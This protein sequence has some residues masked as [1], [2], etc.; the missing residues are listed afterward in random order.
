[1]EDNR[2]TP[3]FVKI[4][5]YEDI[6]NIMN[7]VKKNISQSKSILNKLTEL[8]NQ[9]DIELDKWYSDINEVESKIKM[10]DNTLFE[11]SE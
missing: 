8:K 11:H 7:I 9:E 4:D 2:N 10:I 1:M 5:E 6:I 3:I